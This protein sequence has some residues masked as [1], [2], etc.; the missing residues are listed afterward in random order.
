MREQNLGDG[1][2][3]E[4]IGTALGMGFI[5]PKQLLY[6]G[7]IF[8]ICVPFILRNPTQ[9]LLIFACI[10]GPFWI[11]TGN[12][13]S[14]FFERLNQP[15]KY[16]AEEPILDFNQ[17]GIPMPE[18]PK[19]VSTTYRIKGKRRKYHHLERQYHFLTYGQIELDGRQVGFYLLRRG[20]QLMIIFAWE[21][22]GYDPSIT[23]IQAFTI[24]NNCNDALTALPGDIDLKTYQDI[25]PDCDDYLRMQAEILHR[26]QHDPLSEEIIKSRARRA[27]D[28]KDDGRLL[29]NKITIFA[30]Y[31]LPLGGEYAVSQ[32]WLDELLS[33]T[34]PLVGALQGKNIESK[35]A[36]EK[37]IDYAYRYAYRKVNSTLSADTGF[38]MRVRTLRVQDLYDR[39]YLEL[40]PGPAPKVPQYIVYNHFG[41]QPPVI[42]E[43]ATHA[44]GTLFEAYDGV[45]AKPEFDR[46]YV[47]LPTK[48]RGQ[49]A[50]FVRIGQVRS[51]PK[52]KESVARGYLRY[53]F[54]ILA[55]N[56]E[57]LYGSR[58]VTE[59]TP[60]HSGF[61]Y[62]QLDRI[63]S[64]SVKR[65]ALA[66]KKLTVDVVALRRRE[67]AV[68]A[69]DLLEDSNVPY[70]CSVG[71]WLY[72]DSVD[73]LNQAT[74]DLIQRIRT[75]S[76]ER[77]W[78]NTEHIWLQTWPF[79]WEAFLT[80]PNH[81]RKKYLGFQA[82]PQLPLVKIKPADKKGMMLVSRELNSPIYIDFANRKNHTA[83][84]AKTGAG[85]SNMMLEIILEYLFYDYLAVI[86]D[87]PRPDGSSTYTVLMPLLQR[88]GVRAVYHNVRESV[89]NIIEWPD[90]R[91][92]TRKVDY[93]RRW[94][95]AFQ[96]HV[97]LLCAIVM[98]TTSN[99][100]R[101][102]LVTSLLTQCYADFQADPGIKQRYQAAIEGGFGSDVYQR[103]PILETFV[104]F[105]E[106]WFS[107]YI[108]RK[109]ER[110]SN[111][112]KD[113]IDI[114]VT[115]LRGILPTS[116]GRSING[117]SS[118]DT[119]V[120][121]LV[122]GLTDVAENLDSLIYAMTGLNVL[123]RQSLSAK[124]SLLATDEGTI[125]YKFPFYARETGIIPV[126]G[127]KWGCNF[128]VGAQ[129]IQTILRSCT[130]NEIFKNLDNIFCGYIEDSAIAEMVEQKFREMLLRQYTSEASK[131]SMEL[132]QSY[133]YLKRGDQHLEV[134]HPASEFVLGLGA[135]DPDE[136]AARKRV[137]SLHPGDEIAGLKHFSQLNAQAKRQGLSM[138]L[139][140]PEVTIDETVDISSE[141]AA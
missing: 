72:R 113:T 109:A 29:K 101:E 14:L 68:D 100:D 123:M 25:I 59:L 117:I 34:Q 66:A 44:I 11:L 75:A 107:H 65:E 17:A 92:V 97:R 2:V 110:I 54:N 63:I 94:H 136:D 38:G 129:E 69:R 27:R 76:V 95:Q 12:D 39:D 105:A 112:V 74:S 135:T 118:F 15:K 32:T 6:F 36:W 60:D 19:Q 139:I 79:E 16:I 134:T 131:P 53:I 91:H 23:D 102:L 93:Q 132:L 137:M 115:Q 5:A 126:H 43:P 88:L 77:V 52:D 57:P 128:L 10:Y 127:R 99:P 40:H 7:A 133:W 28:L 22:S 90:L 45:P 86:F 42:N 67:Q 55:G 50:A 119:N 98:G 3:N 48:E 70:W 114:I 89:M 96:N 121:V 47:Y 37:A 1:R 122:V 104:D 31:R 58:V 4:M 24:L 81:K 85:K 35:A 61:E 26:K 103:M 125:L 80:K 73:Q 41:L 106:D 18:N 9:G 64:N 33:K 62:L 116:L 111:L 130:G 51:F 49:Y 140:Y 20:S 46:H 84:I 21:G 8:L 108:D 120:Q 56:N 141:T 82:L 124:R 78:H 13:P 87:F 30:K 71:I 83:I 138:D